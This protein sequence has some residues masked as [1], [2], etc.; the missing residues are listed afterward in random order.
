ASTT[1][2]AA[3]AARGGAPQPRQLVRCLVADAAGHRDDR[4]GLEF[5]RG[6][7]PVIRARS[8]EGDRRAPLCRAQRCTRDHRVHAARSPETQPLDRA[9]GNRAQA[10]TE[11]GAPLWREA[12]GAASLSSG[13]FRSGMMT[14][15]RFGAELHQSGVTFR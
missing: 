5:S 12:G 3:P 7:F 11:R 14:S 10:A 2:S 13:I 4:A 15:V 6:P 1:L 8:A 9:V